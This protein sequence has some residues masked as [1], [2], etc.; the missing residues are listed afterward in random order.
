VTDTPAAWIELG[1]SALARLAAEHRRERDPDA[2]ADDLDELTERWTAARQTFAVALSGDSAFAALAANAGL[3]LA[4]AE[5]LAVAASAELDRRRQRL[6]AFVQDDVTATRIS[7]DTVARV[8]GPEHAGPRAAAP[9]GRL[10]RGAL[11]TTTVDG[12]W[13]DQRIAVHP[14]VVWA[15][16]GD[17]GRDP[18][19]PH[20]TAEVHATSPG[21]VSL[22]TVIG[23]D[24]LRRR[25]VAAE[26]ARGDRFLA[27]GRLDDNAAWAAIVREATIIGAGVIVEVDDALSVEGQRW[28]QRADHLTW[29]ISSRLELAVL[30]LPDRPWVAV[31][32]AD[33]DPSDEEWSAHLG[34][35]PR[36]HRLNLQQL[37]L[38]GRAID[39]YDGDLD[40]AVRRL[41]SGR[42]EHLARRLRPQRSWDDIVLSPDRLALLR[43]I[44]ARYRLAEQVYGE[45]GFSASP[46]RGQVALFSGPSGTGKTLAAEILAGDLGLDVFKLDLSAV[47]SKYIG[48]T[49]K[50]LEEVFD[51]ASAGNLLLFFD[52]A[53]SLFGKRSEVND[54]RDR[55]ANIEVSYLLQRLEVYDG[56]VV[57]ATNFERNIDDAF[58]RRIHTRIEF[59]LPGVEERQ[60]IWDRNLPPGAP[61]KDVDTRWLAAHFELS[62][63]SIRNASVH[64]AFLA[65]AQDSM[66][67]MECAVHGVARELRKLGRLLKAAD[68]GPFGAA[69]ASELG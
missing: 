22:V 12:P 39:A 26:V 46:S 66:I 21:G 43:S 47:V 64:A 44:V 18:D 32:A 55:Y 61:V 20:D 38:V 37:E 5:V 67:T 19:L 27:S 63:G 30:E 15:L 54:A 65:A 68:F 52:E 58:L 40:A 10:N 60:A 24:P 35:A 11:V 53:D 7:L 34:D 8:F 51:A 16:I 59:T 28:V 41:V 14:T 1:H 42:M 57:M 36:S 9:D 48:E 69:V 33:V 31:E 50:N 13:S 23:T 4:E 29:V 45:W 56:L 6:L 49:E 3:S 2:A 25:Q 62:G 17:G